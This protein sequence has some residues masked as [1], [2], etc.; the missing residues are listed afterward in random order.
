MSGDTSRLCFGGDLLDFVRF[1]VY[2]VCGTIELLDLT[3]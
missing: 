2:D 1:D 3:W